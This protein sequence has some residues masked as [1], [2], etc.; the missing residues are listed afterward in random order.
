MKIALDWIATYLDRPIA[1]A[2]AQEALIQGGFVVERVETI[3]GTQVLDVEVTSN[4]P[5]CLSHLG[6]AR[7][8]AALS[9]RRFAAP[10]PRL[11]ETAPAAE[12]WLTVRIAAPDL[13]PYY[14]A[15]VLRGVRV[16]PSPAW[17]RRALATIGLR[18]IN[19]VVDVTNFVLMD[20]G[21]PLH[22]FD[23]AKIAERQI[24]VRRAV[25]GEKITTL[26]GRVHDLT[27]ETLVI[28]DAAAPVALAGI[29]G[30]R[31]SEVVPATRDI[32]LESARFEPF[33]IRRTA[34][35]L[36]LATE[37][38]FR[39]ERGIDPALADYASR[40]AAA[41]LQQVAGG[42]LA[43]GA[44]CT[45]APRQQG[46][47]DCIRTAGCSPAP[48]PG[49]ATVR[50]GAFGDDARTRPQEA[51]ALAVRP[52]RVR[53][54]V[55]VDIPA[56]EMLDILERLGFEPQ[57][58]SDRV[59]CRIPSYRSDISREIDLIEEIL[60][61]WGYARVPVQDQVRHGMPPDDVALQAH[62]TMR[63]TLASCGWQEAITY[64]FVE[65]REA[66]LFLEPGQA[67]VRVS[68]AV[69]K[70]SNTLRPSLWPGLLRARQFNQNQ[71]EAGVRLF[72]HA[73]VYWQDQASPAAPPA[74]EW[75][76]ALIGNS[77]TE[78]LGAVEM[79]LQRLCPGA[80][81]E[82]TPQDRGALA[83]DAAAELLVRV[84]K[85]AG[86]VV[87]HAK[88]GVVGRFAD[89]VLKFYDLR[90]P[91]AGA[92]LRWEV[93]RNWFEPVRRAQA[94]PRFPAVQ[95]DVSVLLG[96]AVRWAEVRATLL[97]ANL[98]Y[99]EALRFVG[100]W[101]GGQME[102]DKKSCTFTLVFRNP[103]GTLRSDEIDVQIQQS[104]KILERQFQAV[105]R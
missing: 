92:E 62:R 15:R 93:W 29:M 12:N 96:A 67:A 14:S 18:S 89:A 75:R 77:V 54:I 39:F 50:V 53:Q 70:L 2:E 24:I 102:S 4:R 105:L 36:G 38:S 52:A 55:G 27:E 84:P 46:R 35:R 42:V 80:E 82:M 88:A 71:G 57:L 101:R 22:A 8:L 6:L 16:G 25:A 59:L 86:A 48:E 31:D 91:A 65:P 78:I 33:N 56:T 83:P 5:D 9:R 30:G 21:Q 87:R 1:A 100:T 60:R 40:R 7:E 10:E 64:S 74:Q 95:R 72:E 37:S 3:D 85:A 68:D 104:L 23:L 97:S 51:V 17:L 63:E 26:D 79:L 44:I 47:N 69:R 43:G 28:S 61:L 41:L 58:E 103:S 94:L 19:N 66:A 45:V 98:Q 81:L 73:A 32:L 34:R 20:T 99:L 13:C 76:V 11:A 49:G 90:H